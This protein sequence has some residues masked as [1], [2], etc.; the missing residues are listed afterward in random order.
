M[1]LEGEIREQR[2][3]LS[4]PK[5]HLRGTHIPE[6]AQPHPLPPC[7]PCPPPDALILRAL[8]SPKQILAPKTCWWPPGSWVPETPSNKATSLCRIPLAA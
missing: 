4:F 7:S 3:F 2:S 5:S 8:N 1:R 6:P